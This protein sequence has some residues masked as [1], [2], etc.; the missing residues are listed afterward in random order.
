M[1]EF[2]RLKYL[3]VT[4]IL[5]PNLKSAL[6]SLSYLIVI[7]SID[8]DRNDPGR[9]Q[10]TSKMGQNDPPTKDEATHPKNWPKQ[11]GPKQPRFVQRYAF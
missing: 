6:L 7:A 10:L 2:M 9:K 8:F 1:Q 5:S 3:S 11:P 4:K